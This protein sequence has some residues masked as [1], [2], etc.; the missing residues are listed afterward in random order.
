MTRQAHVI[1]KERAR[2]ERE[3]AISDEVTQYLSSLFDAARPENT[4]GKPIDAR[5][6]VD[7]GHAEIE[8]RFRDQ[9]EVRARMLAVLASLYCRIGAPERCQ[10][11]ATRGLDLQ[12]SAPSPDP[13]LTASLLHWQG[14]ALVDE[15]RFGLAE[16][17][18]RQAASGLAAQHK[19]GDPDLADTLEALGTALRSLQ[20]HEESI[21]VLEQAKR[22]LT[23]DGSGDVLATANILGSLALSY[24]YMERPD[25]ALETA[26]RSLEIVRSR[27]G[28]GSGA[29]LEALDLYANLLGNMDRFP[30]SSALFQEVVEGY[31]RMFGVDSARTLDAKQDLASTLMGAGRLAEAER[32][33]RQCVD[34]YFRLGVQDGQNYANAAR[35]LGRILFLRGDLEPSVAFLRSAYNSEHARAG[36]N[37]FA[38]LVTG[39]Q[40]ARSLSQLHQFQEARTLL[41]PEVPASLEGDYPQYI[42]ATR[43]R[44][45][46]ELQT[47]TGDYA[48]AHTSFEQSARAFLSVKR[49]VDLLL[50]GVHES[51]GLLLM[52]EGRFQ[53]AVATFRDAFLA[54]QQLLP[55]DSAF[56]QSAAVELA[57]AL[58]AL[59]DS[60]HANALDAAAAPV[61]RRELLPTSTVRQLMR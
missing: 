32:T 53:E 9:P 42:R 49:G 28:T 39:Y 46:G 15:S 12:R 54:Y 21:V 6:L 61:I 14:R 51:A 59:G 35:R 50:A 7:Q 58:R 57:A 40:L 36:E 23:D 11:E 22:L 33:A 18:L 48:S 8:R 30:E 25:E 5:A 44:T 1:G 17:P 19:P 37:A 4:G 55:F 38:A 41:A 24:Q 29:Y 26:R 60:E 16:G 47:E 52:H 13:L 43:L 2:A 27:T 56:R 3:S 20:R 34:T 45:L 31:E 10:A